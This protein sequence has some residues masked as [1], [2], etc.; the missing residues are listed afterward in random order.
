[1]SILV[2][3]LKANGEVPTK[4]SRV[5]IG[6]NFLDLLWRDSQIQLN[7]TPVNSSSNYHYIKSA[8]VKLTTLSK[9]ERSCQHSAGYVYE[10]TTFPNTPNSPSYV[11]REK[12]FRNMVD[13][14][15]P[16]KTERFVGY[17]YSDLKSLQCGIPPG[18]EVKITFNP[19]NPEILIDSY[20]ALPQYKI[21]IDEVKLHVP[22][23][24]LAPSVFNNYMTHLP[25][26]V[27]TMA[28]KRLVVTVLRCEI[29]GLWLLGPTRAVGPPTSYARACTHELTRSA[30]T[31]ARAYSYELTRSAAVQKN[32]KKREKTREIKGGAKDQIFPK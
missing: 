28:F 4:D 8:I 24:Q 29:F 17:I 7:N 30:A 23:A 11:T 2:R 3:L 22:V 31:A 5:A 14:V 9:D 32:R 18:I 21:H 10:D 1:M 26:E 13:G 25:K 27:A 12:I 15:F 20:D 19:N 16:E 6:N